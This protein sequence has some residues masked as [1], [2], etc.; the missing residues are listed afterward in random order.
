M[1]DTAL[2]IPNPLRKSA[3]AHRLWRKT[4]SL[5]DYF[6]F[7]YFWHGLDYIA[8]KLFRQ[9]SDSLVYPPFSGRLL[10][11]AATRVGRKSWG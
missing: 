3:F 2:V 10:C 11:K 4:Y 9:R 8:P 5:N 1:F 7:R 6:V